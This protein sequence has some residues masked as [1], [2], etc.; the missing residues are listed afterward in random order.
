MSFKGKEDAAL[1]QT[2]Q[3]EKTRHPYIPTGVG[4]HPDGRGGF[5]FLNC[6][7]RAHQRLLSRDDQRCH[8]D[9]L[10]AWN[11]L[12]GDLSGGPVVG[13]AAANAGDVSSIPG[14]RTK[15]PHAMRQLSLCS[16]TKEATAVRSPCAATREA[17]LFTVTRESPCRKEE[18]N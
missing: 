8:P 12:W 9:S 10:S 16:A 1:I 3:E 4:L 7:D 11:W 14:P 18:L 5:S 15:I 17:P 13:S 2:P 6:L